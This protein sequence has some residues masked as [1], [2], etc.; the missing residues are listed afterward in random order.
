MANDQAA[1]QHE[2]AQLLRLLSPQQ[3]VDVCAVIGAFNVVDRIADST[4]IALDDM[5]LA[6]SAG[7]PQE[8]GLTNFNSA[9]NTPG[10]R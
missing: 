1:M 9:A 8:L 7:L 4:G 2:R 3:F 10:M 5:M 6:M